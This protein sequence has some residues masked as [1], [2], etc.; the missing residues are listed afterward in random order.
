MSWVSQVCFQPSYAKLSLPEL[1]YKTDTKSPFFSSFSRNHETV[2]AHARRV[3]DWDRTSVL[4][5]LEIAQVYCAILRSR[6]YSAQS[7][8]SENA[9]R[10]L[11]IAQILRLRRTYPFKVVYIYVWQSMNYHLPLKRQASLLLLLPLLS[12]SLVLCF[13]VLRTLSRQHTQT[14]PPLW[15]KHWY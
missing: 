3:K 6:N 1:C 4:R 14:D 11:E 9:Q 7:R 2:S 15:H 10:N 12:L 8:D 13:Y 5:N